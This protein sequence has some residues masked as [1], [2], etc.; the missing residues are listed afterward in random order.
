MMTETID[1]TLAG[2]DF[3][4]VPL[5]HATFDDHDVVYAVLARD[6][7]GEWRVLDVGH[8]NREPERRFHQAERR[9][10]W[11]RWSPTRDLWVAMH[12]PASDFCM[13]EDF[14]NFVHAIRDRYRPP[15]YEE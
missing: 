3:H 1:L 12:R 10:K 5:E 14:E 2:L 13:L 15:C 11:L 7:A 8:S 6:T 4:A 9:A